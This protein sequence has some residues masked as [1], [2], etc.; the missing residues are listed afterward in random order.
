VSEAGEVISQKT[1]DYAM[2]VE[3]QMLAVA[4]EFKSR[5][6]TLGL[7]AADIKEKKLYEVLGHDSEQAYREYLGIGRSTYFRCRRLAQEIAQPLLKKELVTRARLNR[8]TLEN[9]EQLLRLDIRRRFSE[10]WVEKSLTMT[11]SQFEAQVDHVLENDTEPE[12][13]VDVDALAVLKIRMTASQKQ[14]ILATF[15]EFARAQDP[16]LE[17]DDHSHILEFMCAEVHN[18][19]QTEAE[20]VGA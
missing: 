13:V 12:D 1:K 2:K 8:L 5:Y 16:P 6:W 4:G 19:L 7:G 9:A 3:E 11:E 14:V 10:S 18:T 20:E 15:E 17:V